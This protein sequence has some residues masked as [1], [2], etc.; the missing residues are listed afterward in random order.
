VK[1]CGE[2][3]ILGCPAGTGIWSRERK[4][5]IKGLLFFRTVIGPI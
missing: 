1:S 2:R 4:T 5:A 3:P